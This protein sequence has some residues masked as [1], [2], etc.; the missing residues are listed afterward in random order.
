MH[1]L[2]VKYYKKQSNK[3]QFFIYLLCY[4]A[5]FVIAWIA[6]NMVLLMGERS[7]I[8]QDDSM[9]TY[10]MLAHGRRIAEEVFQNVLV[11]HKFNI[12]WV[13][14]NLTGENNLLCITVH[15]FFDIFYW[16]V[17]KRHFETVYSIIIILRLW[18]VGISF[19]LYCIRRG[20]RKRYILPGSLIYAFCGYAIFYGNVQPTFMSML[21]MTPIIFIG[22]EDIF[23]KGDGK[24]FSLMVFL[25]FFHC[26]F[27]TYY[28]TVVIGLYF[29]GRCAEKRLNYYEV[30]KKSLKIG[31]HYI[32]GFGVGGFVFVPEAIGILA[33]GRMQSGMHLSLTYGAS[34]L[35]RMIK[36]F[37]ILENAPKDSFMGFSVTVMFP[38][39]YLFLVAQKDKIFR[40]FFVFLFSL[41]NLPIFGLVAG[42]G[43]INNRWSYFLAFFIAYIF[44]K[45]V[46]E[47]LIGLPKNKRK[48][49]NLAAIFFVLFLFCLNKESSSSSAVKLEILAL[50]TMIFCMNIIW[51]IN[52]VYVSIA[53][54]T[55]MAVLSAAM[56][57][58]SIYSSEFG[59]MAQYYAQ[60]GCVNEVLDSYIDASAEQ[61]TDGS[62]FRIDKS[63]FNDELSCNLPYWYG[64][65]GVS[66]FSNTLNA[67]SVEYFKK[68]ENTGML[69]ANKYADLGGKV[70]DEALAGIKY[71]L[72][73][74]KE[75]ETVPY[76][77]ERINGAAE[78]KQY[79]LY[80]N[81]YALPLGFTYEDVISIDEFDRLSIAQKQEVLL[82][83]ILL[84]GDIK[85]GDTGTEHLK[86]R[87]LGL[88]IVESYN[89][90]ETDNGWHV[91]GKKAYIK[92]IIDAQGESEL[93]LRVSD[94]ENKSEANCV[95]TVET[96]GK[97]EAAYSHGISSERSNGQQ[98][99][100]F[101]IGKE[102]DGKVEVTLSFAQNRDV[103][104]G[105]I[106]AYARDLSLYKEDIKRLTKE[107][108]EDIYVGTNNIK[109][110]IDVKNSKYLCFSIPYS[111]GWSCY[112]DGEKTEILKANIMYM[113]VKLE[114]GTHQIE[115]RY[116]PQGMYL[117]MIISLVT[118]FAIIGIIVSKKGYREKGRIK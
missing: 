59:N 101:N 1:N 102:I 72:V 54:F 51:K 17:S 5:A 112:V 29:F 111:K 23:D 40:V 81:R 86:S 16:V 94:V 117:G 98:E 116:V 93:Y 76:G 22:I 49:M 31:I 79:A 55:V 104:V 75:A 52:K 58:I 33:S 25:S 62:F 88:H 36:N 103:F 67:S 91:I 109:G 96:L 85:K 110:C 80:E 38:L 35:S 18:L 71:Y 11:S 53:V 107:C 78:N 6:T 15:E 3:Y 90:E 97:K 41:M 63:E 8:L 20:H 100:T 42:A 43:I 21:Y 32:I 50:I 108:L 118:L 83:R 64:F 26:F 73:N 74:K 19:S 82:K 48:H 99:F 95:I 77:F 61:I 89:M 44:V 10:E 12:P 24:L 47:L 106:Q 114:E 30:I 65:N 92:M 84:E 14:Y 46:P 39:I 113:A 105:R 45:F 87:E 13:N 66:S 56:N 4:S 28:N 37:F 2:M 115:L 7:L 9:A 27:T 70:T 60:K 68:M 69:Q 34:Y 57:G